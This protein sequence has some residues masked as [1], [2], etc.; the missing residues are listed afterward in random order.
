MLT[1]PPPNRTRPA[2]GLRTAFLS[3]LMLS[4]VAVGACE[5]ESVSQTADAIAPTPPPAAAAAPQTEPAR[6]VSAPEL[7]QSGIEQFVS[8]NARRAA[9]AAESVRGLDREYLEPR[10]IS[11]G[12][13]AAEIAA[14][15]AD[16]DAEDVRHRDRALQLLGVLPAGQ[17]LD[18]IYLALVPDQ[19]I[20]FYL[21]EEDELYVV[22]PAE[23]GQSATDQALITLAHEYIHALQQAHFDI[24]SLSE[25]IPVLD[26]DRQ[27]A[28]S[29]LIEGDASVFGFAAVAEQVDLRA[30]QSAQQALPPDL[31]RP[32]EFVLQLLAYPY[33]A[34]SE[35]VLGVLLGS[36]LPGLNGL[37]A[38]SGVPR[39]TAQITPL[40]LRSEW[41]DSSTAEFAAPELP[42]W[43]SLAT[44]S[45]GQFVLG[46]LLGDQ[47]EQGQR[48][49]AGWIDDH[50]LL[51][52]NGMTEV[53]LY[54]A[55]FGDR[56]AAEDFFVQF[57]DLIAG[58]RLDH[59]G[60][61]G[62]V[63]ASGAES[64]SWRLGQRTALAALDG[65]GVSLVVGD[66]A[67]AADAAARSLAGDPAADLAEGDYC[68]E[69]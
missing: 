56:A 12:E 44:G 23:F 32:G 25:A 59:A 27:L 54:R 20:G 38:S 43:E 35:Y 29:A 57:R 30:L 6:P 21:A 24:R 64:I 3:L 1:V 40:G 5:S 62:S 17:G 45:L 31:G 63:S 41:R 52:G 55:E 46:V 49:P 65:S 60:R 16:Q 48:G 51:I 69:Q 4:G 33:V 68:P 50:L 8:E 58:D 67:R 42:C 9:D 28:L 14:A 37:Y 2:G 47:V 26:F 7:R 18:D 15:L 53:L 13:A 11:P 61:A 34:G 66:H 22:E 10:I 19:V 39:A 36:G